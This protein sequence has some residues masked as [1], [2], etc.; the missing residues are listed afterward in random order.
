MLHSRLSAMV[1]K[2]LFNEIKWG[3]ACSYAGNVA[4]FTN[5]CLSF[6]NVVDARGPEQ[7]VARSPDFFAVFF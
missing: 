1:E 4:I 7:E 2:K 6:G 3:L 5:L